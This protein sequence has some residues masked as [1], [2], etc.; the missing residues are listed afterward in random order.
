MSADALPAV[1][2]VHHTSFTVS[3]LDRA[4]GF[5]RDCLG[6]PLV[7]RAPRD[8]AV[9]AAVT[10]VPGAQVEIAYV[11]GPGHDVEL[12][13]YHAPADRGATRPRPCD[14]GFAH[15]ALTVR[16]LDEIVAAAERHGVT[17]VAPPV[18]NSGQGPIAGAR[19]IYL[20]DADGITIELIETRN[21]AR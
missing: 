18:T 16:G 4:V 2:G 12:I 1:L 8:P 11:R 17:T 21:A 13:E 5:F 9:I 15:L 14:A 3:S 6:F 19:V 7:S 20:R 10:G